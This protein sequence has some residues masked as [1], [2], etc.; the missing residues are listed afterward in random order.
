MVRRGSPAR[1]SIHRPRG[2]VFTHPGSG[3]S[4]VSPFGA[5]SRPFIGRESLAELTGRKRFNHLYRRAGLGAS[6][7]EVNGAMALHPNE[8]TAFSMAVDNLLNYNAVSE[9]PDLFQPDGS[10][11]S[12]ILRS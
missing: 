10:T 4:S 6:E 3:R 5:Q 9:T 2:A 7:V 1:Q 8:D 11:V 12:L